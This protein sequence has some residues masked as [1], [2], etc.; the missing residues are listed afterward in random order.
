VTTV[1]LGITVPAADG[2]HAPAAGTME[3]TP[4]A[5]RV[6]GDDVVLP[7][8]FVVTL[9]G[10]GTVTVAATDGWWV[11]RVRERFPG[12][13]PLPRYVAVPD[14]D[15]PVDYADLVA[16]D[17]A[18]LVSTAEP[19][20]AWWAALDALGEV[21]PEQIAASVSDYLAE[22]PPDV[23]GVPGPQGPQGPPGPIG[24]AG[25]AGAA[26]E[27][28]PIGPPGPKGDPGDPGPAG[29]V[30]PQGEQGPA[31]DT[32]PA[33]PEGPEGPAGP[34]GDIG[35]AGPQ[36]D[37]GPKGD[38]GEPG[39]T[40][41]TGPQGPEGPAGPKGDKGDTG[42]QGPA[43]QGVLVLAAGDPIPGGTPTGTVILR[44]A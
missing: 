10:D 29:Q 38:P 43:G 32:G 25:P 41:D 30:G 4:T 19:S 7:A 15:E 35:P 5:R 33:G 13:S 40:G 23:E 39:A 22:N 36:G 31:G 3:W 28:G 26:G 24:P 17:P 42:P 9:P 27:Q 20:A 37:P 34:A 18:T 1:R 8:P 11:W 16:V 12:G 6:V 44:T 14:S 21:D 2:A